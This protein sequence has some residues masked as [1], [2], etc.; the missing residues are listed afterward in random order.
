MFM[1]FNNIKIIVA[2]FV[3]AFYSCNPG[4]EPEA[5]L[6]IPSEAQVEWQK[7][8]PMHLYILD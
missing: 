1:Y 3:L 8:R 4:T 7:W 6:P 5:I 2:L